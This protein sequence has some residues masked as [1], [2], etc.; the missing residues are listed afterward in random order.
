MYH[1]DKKKSNAV[2]YE[3]PQQH[4]FATILLVVQTFFVVVKYCYLFA[5]HPLPVLLIPN[6]KKRTHTKKRTHRIAVAAATAVDAAAAFLLKKKTA[7]LHTA[8]LND[9]IYHNLLSKVHIYSGAPKYNPV[10][11]GHSYSGRY[12][13]SPTINTL[14][15]KPVCFGHTR[16]GTRLPP[17]YKPQDQTCWFWPYLGRYPA[18]PRLHILRP[19]LL[20]L[21]ILG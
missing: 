3:Q 2:N 18:T 16:V 15:T 20:V 7:A 17:E 1:A 13:G 9:T 14:N 4:S 12:P 5:F 10:R 11:F 8:C 6:N 19:N 21:V